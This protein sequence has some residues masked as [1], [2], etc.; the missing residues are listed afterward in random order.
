MKQLPNI[1][2][3]HI[4]PY[5]GVCSRYITCLEKTMPVTAFQLYFKVF[6]QRNTI[7]VKILLAKFLWLEVVKDVSLLNEWKKSRNED[8]EWFGDKHC[9]IL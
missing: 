2:K 5:N 4:G 6:C 3:K 1:F 7:Q 8:K 9:F